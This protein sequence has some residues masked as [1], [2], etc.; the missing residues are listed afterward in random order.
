MRPL[1]RA[2][3]LA[4]ALSTSTASAWAGDV[5]SAERDQRAGAQKTF[6][7]GSKLYDTRHFEEALAAFRASYQI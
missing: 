3:L 5:Q 4:G 2:L 7:A 1:A 6:E